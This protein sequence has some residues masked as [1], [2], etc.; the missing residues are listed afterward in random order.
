MHKNKWQN[1][2]KISNTLKIKETLAFWKKEG[3]SVGVDEIER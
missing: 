3:Y 1:L 2:C